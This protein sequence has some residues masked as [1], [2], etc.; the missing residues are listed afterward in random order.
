MDTNIC[1]FNRPFEVLP[2]L[3]ISTRYCYMQRGLR[4]LFPLERLPH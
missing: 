2:G 4:D 3:H 1:H